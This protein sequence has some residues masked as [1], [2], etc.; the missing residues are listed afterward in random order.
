MSR[1]HLIIPLLIFSAAVMSVAMLASPRA[2]WGQMTIPTRTPTPGPDTDPP[3]T[4]PPDDGGGDNGGGGGGDN[5]GGGNNQQPPSNPTNTP[6]PQGPPATATPAG[7]QATATPATEATTPTAT[8]PA[9]TPSATP[10]VTVIEYMAPNTTRVPYPDTEEYPEAEECEEPPTI[11]TLATTTMY[12]GPGSDYD[13]V[14]ALERDAVRP[15]VGRAQYGP[16]WLVQLDPSGRQ[17]WI[18][19]KAVAVSGNT[20]NVPLI[21]ADPIDDASPT[22]GPTWEPTP[23]VNCDVTKT[24]TPTATATEAAGIGAGSAA[25][26]ESEVSSSG[27]EEIAAPTPAPLDIEADSQTPNFLPIAGL[28]LV[29]AAVFLALFLRRNPG[30]DASG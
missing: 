6:V 13:V 25:A 3:P 20:A 16:W 4:T 17:A 19:D 9:T 22:P 12:V 5:G 11:R 30:G 14:V 1:R 26:A 8:R 27:S 10:F 21:P 23:A 24:A 2:A 7:T 28:V 29:V 15:I 18:S